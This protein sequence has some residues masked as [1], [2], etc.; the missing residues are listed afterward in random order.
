MTTGRS[1]PVVCLALGLQLVLG[2]VDQS[3]LNSP[4][5][6]NV[7]EAAPDIGVPVSVQHGE[8]HFADLARQVPSS[9]GY[10][11]DSTGTLVVLVRDAGEDAAAVG[12]MS[13]R[14]QAERLRSGDG[15]GAA[16]RITT[17]RATYTFK[18]LAEWRDLV[19]TE[20]RRVNRGIA[21]LDLDEVLN[22]VTIGLIPNDEAKRQAVTNSLARFGVPSEALNFENVAKVRNDA[23]PSSLLSETTDPIAA[24]LIVDLAGGGSCSVGFVAQRNGTL[25]LV[26]ATHCT[27]SVFGVDGIQLYQRIQTSNV[28]AQETVDPAGYQCGW[29]KCRGSDASFFSQSNGRAMQV[30]LMARTQ[31]P[32]TGGW[33]AGAG[34]T[35]VNSTNP[36]FFVTGQLDNPVVGQVVQKIGW[37]AGWTSGSVT[38]TCK[39]YNLLD[40]PPEFHQITCGLY[41]TYYSQG[42]DSGGPVFVYD[43]NCPIFDNVYGLPLCVKLVGIH[44][45]HADV[46]SHASYAS[47]I[48]S[49]MGGTWTTNYT[50]SLGAPSP[51]AG[52]DDG[53]PL[54]SWQSVSGASK[55]DV[56]RKPSCGSQWIYAGT[57]TTTSLVDTPVDAQSIQSTQVPCG[58]SGVSYYVAA[59]TSTAYSP[60]STLLHYATFPSPPPALSVDLSGQ[61]TID[62]SASCIWTASA[63]GGDGSY[64]YKWYSNGVLIPNQTSSSITLSGASAPFQVSVIVK[65]GVN[66]SASDLMSVASQS[67]AF[68]S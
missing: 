44:S 31:V 33:G 46:E 25:G 13:V 65:D 7:P 2:C 27:P 32:S 40:F 68:C 1:I 66:H 5:L 34:S 14:V 11:F 53:H 35:S 41:A 15:R 55:Y 22:R 39:D 43:F 23:A 18:Q 61:D 20:A 17:R 10:Y 45:N 12:A 28:A 30:G 50:A 8:L 60:A 38:Q 37:G 56:Y 42:G 19:H 21:S 4:L 62:P 49:D 9:A 3:K 67:G 24:G 52:F 58:Q 64:T 51:S 6:Q 16:P 26:S 36:Y 57:T 59:R 47:R 48:K 29:D 63:S 54:L